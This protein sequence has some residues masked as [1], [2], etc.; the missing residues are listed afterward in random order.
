KGEGR[1]SSREEYPLPHL[2]LLDLKMPRTDGFDVLRWIRHQPGLSSLRVLV[3]TG[4]DHIRD[5]NQAYQLGANS[6]M[7]K[8]DDFQ[9]FVQ[10]SKNLQTHWLGQRKAP[11][12]SPL[13]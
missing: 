5:V 1:F 9:N 12:N 8:P 13:A 6:F 7:V 2:L 3:L 10:L 4:S 11:Q